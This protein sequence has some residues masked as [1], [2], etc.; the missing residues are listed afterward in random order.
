M[1][2][3]I[4]TTILLS[5]L[6][7][8]SLAILVRQQI[9]VV[10]ANQPF[11]PSDGDA[12]TENND[13]SY[14]WLCSPSYPDTISFTST[15][16][17]VGS[18]SLMV[19]HTSATSYMAFSVDIG[20]ATD[21]SGASYFSFWLYYNGSSAKPLQILM[22]QSD[23]FSGNHFTYNYG[24]G[25]PLNQWFQ[26]YLPPSSFTN[27]GAA[28]SNLRYI[29]FQFGPGLGSSDY[30]SVYIDGLR[31]ESTA[32][33][34]SSLD[35][36][37]ESNESATWFTP[38]SFPDVVSYSTDH[39]LFNSYSLKVNHTSASSYLE[40][41][42]VFTPT[43]MTTYKAISFSLC[44]QSSQ[45]TIPM[46]LY[47]SNSNSLLSTTYQYDATYGSAPLTNQWVNFSIPLG[48]FTNTTASSS[49]NAIQ[50]IDFVFG[51]VSASDCTC[52]YIDG[53]YI[54]QDFTY[55]TASDSVNAAIMPKILSYIYQNQVN[56]SYNGNTYTG[57][58]CMMPLNNGTDSDPE[59]QSET[60]AET[61]FGL[62]LAYNCTHYDFLFDQAN[63]YWN[64][65]AC[66]QDQSTGA[67]YP[68]YSN[69]TGFTKGYDSATV[70][71]W[72][73]AAGSMLYS[74]TSNSS[75]KA[76]L[77]RTI[78][79]G[80]SIM[81]NST[82]NRFNLDYNWGPPVTITYPTV[83]N[84]QSWDTMKEGAMI[85]GF[86]AYYTYVAQNST[87]LSC[88]NAAANSALN[89]QQSTGISIT[90][91][92]NSPFEDNTYQYWGFF[93]AYLATGSVTYR[94]TLVNFENLLFATNEVNQNAS[95]PYYTWDT[96]SPMQTSQVFDGW[97]WACSLP[98]W[99]EM[100]LLTRNQHLL[101]LYEI[102]VGDTLPQILTQSNSI[103]RM[104]G[105]TTWN[106]LQ[107]TPSN[108]FIYAS[109]AMYYNI[110]FPTPE[111]TQPPSPQ[112]TQPTQSS[113]PKSTQSTQPTQSSSPQPTQPTQSPIFQTRQQQSWIGQTSLIFIPAAL[114]VIMIFTVVF[115]RKLKPMHEKKVPLQPCRAKT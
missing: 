63:I 102:A 22:Y 5:L 82:Y 23:R 93:F 114:V 16:A 80:T 50:Q 79:Y 4:L 87:V 1:K 109:L 72:I 31:S 106:S 92:S 90:F 43:D 112:P 3:K 101:N 57:L 13:A 11:I 85:A 65:L 33:F 59:L 15:K 53:L 111:P 21:F 99:L 97:G 74:F 83:T 28:W 35:T 54:K 77:D 94:T 67:F 19:N 107:Y 41:G 55:Y 91:S 10:K 115:R 12:W 73:L 108:A 104:R 42:T 70:D 20:A 44:V 69:T 48:I 29:C 86:G 18:Y 89:V 78:N 34:P 61:I 24:T 14:P 84:P 60:L 62:L 88:L 45:A 103:T 40:F 95:V 36:L 64:W 39:V 6:I 100:C 37:T 56:Y 25:Y 75:I 98:L 30:T 68:T 105:N 96:F 110:P 2:K 26:L 76:V 113:S 38:G 9:P 66:Y 58:N 27:T 17:M 47:F 52:V 46:Y 7:M 49:W 71:G 81:W 32:Q 8:A 51:P